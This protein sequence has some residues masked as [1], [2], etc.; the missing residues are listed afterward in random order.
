M[1]Q[2]MEFGEILHTTPENE[3][4]DNVTHFIH[5]KLTKLRTDN[6]ECFC[7]PVCF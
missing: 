7:S 5:I 6:S 1:S 3:N 4:R 2:N